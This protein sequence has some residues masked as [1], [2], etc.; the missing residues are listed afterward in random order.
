MLNFLSLLRGQ[1]NA[2]KSYIILFNYCRP[3]KVR[4]KKVKETVKPPPVIFIMVS[5]DKKT[6]SSDQ[7]IPA[8]GSVPKTADNQK[9]YQKTTPVPIRP[10]GLPS[11][12]LP[13][14]LIS[15]INQKESLS[16]GRTVAKSLVT[17][18][19]CSINRPYLND[20]NRI[21]TSA[22]PMTTSQS[23]VC[24]LLEK[25]SEGCQTEV[26]SSQS[27]A[28][29]ACCQTDDYVSE[30][31]AQTH[32]DMTLF[33]PSVNQKALSFENQSA[34]TQHTSVSFD[35]DNGELIQSGHLLPFTV[36]TGTQ[37]QVAPCKKSA[38]ETQTSGNY[39]LEKAMEN[40]H[41]PVVKR[42]RSSQ[43]SSAHVRKARKTNS[44]QTQTGRGGVTRKHSA[45]TNTVIRNDQRKSRRVRKTSSPKTMSAK[46]LPRATTARLQ[47]TTDFGNQI[48][49]DFSQNLCDFADNETQ[50]MA[51]LDDLEAS[52]GE[53]IS[54][55][56]LESYLTDNPLTDS[57]TLVQNSSVQ[58]METNLTAETSIQDFDMNYFHE[59]EF[60]TSDKND[61]DTFSVS[62]FIVSRSKS[63]EMLPSE[64]G[65]TSTKTSDN[66]PID[67]SLKPFTSLCNNEKVGAD[68][69]SVNRSQSPENVWKAY[70]HQA[71]TTQTQTT[72]TSKIQN[73]TQTVTLDDLPQISMHTQ[74]LDFDRFCRTNMET[75]TLTADSSYTSH[76]HTQTLEL[77]SFCQSNMET[78]TFDMELCQTHNETQTVDD[79][80]NQLLS[81]METQTVGNLDFGDF[82]LTDIQTQTSLSQESYLS[83]GSQTLLN[84]L[85]DNS[86]LSMDIETQT[87]LALTQAPP[88]G[89][90]TQLT[91]IETQT[92]FPELDLTDTYTQTQMSFL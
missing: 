14:P 88:Q 73:Q 51:L 92:L 15:S 32:N 75:Q 40:A 86:V 76:M 8:S 41:L 42:S 56:T 74:T 35:S 91:N 5:N 89:H 64:N 22:L 18:E 77:D 45:A 25:S 11:I 49:N 33:D 24:T 19:R 17:V 34:Q 71:T 28:I 3:S 65:K 4:E 53:S 46:Q 44:S 13:I 55:Q 16:A 39:I 9:S 12:Q 2:T 63:E 78:Q 29:A 67:I 66:I 60:H 50:T 6:S 70:N 90:D 83:M 26:S 59:N 7:S 58:T 1:Y 72:P 38:V 47:V 10:K 62:D 85:E 31:S 20:R 80:F 82:E 27:V 81:N 23:N 87:N 30:Q 37:A 43:A 57:E 36:S 61:L 52:L 84:A 48:L 68:E 21:S 69:E 79:M 54:T